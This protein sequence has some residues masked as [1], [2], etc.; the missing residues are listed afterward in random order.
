MV[1]KSKKPLQKNKKKL[2]IIMRGSKSASNIM[3]GDKNFGH[4]LFEDH[5]FIYLYIFYL[6]FF[7]TR[8]FKAI[9][10]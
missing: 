5:L 6:F 2:L 3:N 8:L 4:I 1:K 7:A 9:R 10:N